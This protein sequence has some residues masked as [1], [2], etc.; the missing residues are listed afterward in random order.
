MDT[1]NCGREGIRVSRGR[2]E[3]NPHPRSFKE[4]PADPVRVDGTRKGFKKLN[5]SWD[6]L[7]LPLHHRV[8]DRKQRDRIFKKSQVNQRSSRQFPFYQEL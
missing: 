8:S 2:V 4:I 5:G 7:Q 6:R 1:F 3:I